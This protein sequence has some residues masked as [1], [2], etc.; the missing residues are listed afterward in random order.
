VL[1]TGTV[2]DDRRPALIAAALQ[3]L[4]RDH[5]N[6]SD[7]AV[8]P[9]P[10]GA[11]I[12]DASGSFVWL[13]EQPERLLGAAIALHLRKA[14]NRLDIVLPDV[15]RKLAPTVARRAAQW[16]IP[17]DVFSLEGTSLET[18]QP[19]PAD[20]E[21]DCEFDSDQFRAVISEAGA[22]VVI[23]HGVLTGEVAGLEV[24]RVVFEEEWRLRV[25]VGSQDREA[26]HMLH[27][28]APAL[29]SLVRVVEFVQLYRRPSADPHPLNRLSPERWMR[30]TFLADESHAL[31]V[32]TQM[33]GVLPRGSMSDAAPSFA[34]QERNGAR[35]LLAF[36]TGTDL[37]AVVDAADHA[38]WSAHRNEVS[39]I[40][41]VV[42]GRNRLPVLDVIAE[43]SVRPMRIISQSELTS[44]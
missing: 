3:A 31:G 16:N 33:S 21:A 43:R 44:L 30:S 35:V 24:C 4:A 9:F 15:H 41:V 26:F 29:E 34:V 37:G 25:G 18:V 22:E 2:G 23:E 11:G 32:V 20:A 38:E 39:E 14:T 12:H 28:D 36:T 40:I 5:R 6:I 1:E 10:G 7:S 17:I 42:D 27:G 8:I 13:D 19:Q